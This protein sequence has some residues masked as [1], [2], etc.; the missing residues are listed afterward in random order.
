MGIYV[1]YCSVNCY[2]TGVEVGSPK[3][4]PPS[5]SGGHKILEE[6]PEGGIEMAVIQ[7]T[8]D[9]KVNIFE[10]WVSL[11]NLIPFEV[12]FNSIGAVPLKYWTHK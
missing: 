10:A 9:E 4:A 2:F 1:I 12:S 7:N 5:T 8:P 6:E 3:K 11:L